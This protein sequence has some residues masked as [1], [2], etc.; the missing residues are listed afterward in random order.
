M[1]YD[2][3]HSLESGLENDPITADSLRDLDLRYDI[4]KLKIVIHVSKCDT[5]HVS[6]C[7]TIHVSKCDTVSNIAP[8]VAWKT[9]PSARI[10][11]AFSS[12][13]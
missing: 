4:S 6:K 5:I 11:S 12:S 1:R 10:A 3:Q 13:S 8:S 9:T 7:D 2:I